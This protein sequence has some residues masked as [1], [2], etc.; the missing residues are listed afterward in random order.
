[1][2]SLF[3]MDHADFFLRTTLNSSAILQSL[4]QHCKL[5]FRFCDEKNT[6][7]VHDIICNAIAQALSRPTLNGGLPKH[8]VL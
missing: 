6:K 5:L 4:G 2:L 3:K 8:Q 7:A 1:M